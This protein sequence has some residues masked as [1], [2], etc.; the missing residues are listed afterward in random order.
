MKEEITVSQRLGEFVHGLQ[1][2]ALP[3]EV[4]AVAKLRVL[5][6]VG[7]CLASVGMP[8]AEAIYNL[9]CEQG[10]PQVAQAFGRSERMPEVWAGLYNG[11]LAH[12]NDFDDTHS[13]SIVHIG[14]AVVPSALAVSERLG[15]SGRSVLTAVVAGYEVAARIGMAASK[16]FHAQGFHPT[17]VCGVF[18]AAATAGK[19][20]GLS[21]TQIAN[22]FGVAGSQASGSLE[23][24]EDGAWTKRMHPGW[25]AHAGIIAAGLARRGFIGP[26]RTFEGRYGLYKLYANTVTPDLDLATRALGH[27]WEILNTD[28]KPYPCGHISHPYMDCALRLKAEHDL[29]P[30]EI[31]A[32]ELRVPAAAV[33]ILCEP[34]EAKR[35]PQNSY[36]ARFSLPYAVA[37]ILVE[38]RAGIDEFSEDAISNT[39]V[40]GLCERTTYVVD[41]SLPFPRSFPGWVVIRLRSGRTLEFRMDAS[42]GSREIPMTMDEVRQKFMTNAVRALPRQQAEL[43]W[44]NG[45]ALESCENVSEFSSLTKAQKS[46]G[47]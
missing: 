18:S 43:L 37:A 47:N 45:L 8:Y 1:Y 21:A 29:K 40:L 12:G 36:A 34:L 4:V 38:G 2:S 17:G 28:F 31:E 5:D 16:G 26:R 33:P 3:D 14:G 15:S 30:E 23:F 11:S 39:R 44:E 42:R 41:E 46:G 35:R 32:I 19:L 20:I 25:S 27:E 24:L 10:G 13:R 7:V 22:A 6:T 9:C